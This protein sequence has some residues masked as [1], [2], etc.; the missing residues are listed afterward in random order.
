MEALRKAFP[1]PRTRLL[2]GGGATEQVLRE[3]ASGAGVLHVSAHGAFPERNP[4]DYH[5]ILLSPA[6]GS[7]GD[8]H[9][10]EVRAL[11]LSNAGMVVLAI[12]N[13]GLY[14]F[15][16]SDEPYGLVPAFLAAGASN[17]LGTLWPLEDSFGR[18]FA[19]RLYDRLVD[20]GPAEA[21]RQAALSA[22][23]DEE[24]IRRWAG[25]VLVG[26]GRPYD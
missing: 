4:L 8:F 26:P 21:L 16:P 19:A 24:L 20:E 12:C 2:E 15:G 1:G 13:G 11:N 5:K 3:L 25:F 14:S 9:A 23:R 22:I 18:Q 6:G 17:V 10:H 7:D